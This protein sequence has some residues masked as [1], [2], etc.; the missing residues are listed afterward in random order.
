MTKKRATLFVSIVTLTL[1]LS[2]ILT[3]SIFAK[4]YPIT[5]MTELELAKLY[6]ETL[7]FTDYLPLPEGAIEI[8]GEVKNIVIGFS[9]TG[10]G[11][12]WRAEMIAA[13]QAEVARHPNVD[14][15]ITDGTVDIQKQSNDIRDLLARN[16][17]GI[18][19][20]PVESAGL[21]PAAMRVNAANKPLVVLDRDIPAD[22]TLFLG[23]SNIK[24]AEELAK[25]M[26]EDLGGKGKILHITGL[27]GSSPAID[28]AQGLYNV[29]EE[30]P[31]IEILAEGD[32]QWVREPAVGLMENWLTAYDD[33]D[34]IFSHAEESSWGAQIAIGRAGRCD[35]NILHY[36]HDGSNAG[37]KSVKRG[38][39]QG[40]GNYTPY[41]GDIG[42][43]AVLYELMG[44]EIKGKVK[45]ENPGWKIE[46]P[47]LPNV[48]PEN[49]DEW[50]GKGWGE[51]EPPTDPCL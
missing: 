2:F 49:A 48:V 3:G 21:A 38:T 6:K 51:F 41:I 29:L 23:Q 45:Y 26:V 13:A 25:R 27:M 44:K 10:F 35:E 32:G 40:D 33:I 28:R 39:F 12:P 20:S 15:V 42:V 43:R 7:P 8:D 22:K 46:L 1:V 30:Y 24:M 18:V 36:V 11:H 16:V 50:I 19:L 37:F 14:L 9:Q 4:T 34:A 5:N 47:P 17:D 31:E